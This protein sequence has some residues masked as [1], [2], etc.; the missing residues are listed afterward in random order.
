MDG[1]YRAAHNLTDEQVLEHNQA[2]SQSSPQVFQLPPSL[3]ANFPALP[4]PAHPTDLLTPFSTGSTSDLFRAIVKRPNPISIEING[5]LHS[6][7]SDI[8]IQFAA[9]LRV[10]KKVGKNTGFVA[11][12]G[13]VENLGMVLEW[14][15]GP[16]LLD[17]L[18]GPAPPNRMTKPPPHKNPSKKRRIKWHNQLVDALV[19]LHSFGLNHGDLSLLNIHV[20]TRTDNIKLIDFGRSVSVAGYPCEHI[21]L[22]DPER[23]TPTLK[24]DKKLPPGAAPP[25]QIFRPGGAWVDS[26]SDSRQ[27]RQGSSKHGKETDYGGR[28]R[29]H[30]RSSN[31]SAKP[32]LTLGML[33]AAIPEVDGLPAPRP[34]NHASRL[35]QQHPSSPASPSLGTHIPVTLS[36][37]GRPGKDAPSTPLSAR[38][39]SS[40]PV[41]TRHH[42][43]TSPMST[44]QAHD[45]DGQSNEGDD[46]YGQ[47]D[48]MQVDHQG[49][50]HGLP[51]PVST[52]TNVNLPDFGYDAHPYPSPLRRDPLGY[53]YGGHD[54]RREAHY[55][56]SSSAGYALSPP[57]SRPSSRRPSPA[58]FSTA[59][60]YANS[61][62]RLHPSR[63]HHAQSLSHSHGYVPEYEYEYDQGRRSHSTSRSRHSRS[64]TPSRSHRATPQRGYSE[65]HPDGSYPAHAYPGQHS[66]SRPQPTP[67]PPAPPRPQPAKAEQIHPG[68]RPFCAPEILRASSGTCIDSRTKQWIDPIL[69]DAYSFGIILVC[70]DLCKLVDCSGEKQKREDGKFPDLSETTM[71]TELIRGYVKPAG[72]RVR[73]TLDRK[74]VVPEEDEE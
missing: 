72:E 21:Y 60:E 22:P 1:G 23:E 67:L 39:S 43:S 8:A 38:P 56:A 63:P 54:L 71:F 5:E 11:Y 49:Y 69:A 18:R 64:P 15:E 53:G 13:C 36:R 24:G 68:S 3:V 51:P 70:M 25:P 17:A 32:N 33:D 28:P 7:A 46:G 41:A 44:R 57:H 73:I 9:E 59:A 47:D 61:P 30:E 66:R 6:N 50:G 14:V 20:E 27:G 2:G 74:L 37:S 4:A 19:H 34:I 45:H 26:T 48:W 40:S 65:D 35:L 16:T 42:L 52:S 55:G 12:L 62:R 31:S 58:R 10:Y 29:L